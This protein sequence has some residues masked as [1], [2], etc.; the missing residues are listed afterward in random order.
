[1]HRNIRLFY[2]HNLLTDFQFHAPFIVI[3]F[4][5]I[6]GSYTQAM[7]ILSIATITAVLMDIPSGVLSD[8]IGRKFTITMG[9]LFSVLGIS[10]YAAASSVELLYL[11][12]ALCGLSHCMFS[13]NNDALLFE[14]LKEQGKENLF[15][16]Y[17]GRTSSMFQ[18]ALSLSALTAVFLVTDNLRLVFILS[19]VPQVLALI[20]SLMFKSPKIHTTTQR[21]S[22]QHIAESISKIWHNPKLLL[23][24][25]GQSISHG[26][27]EANFEFKTVFVNSLWPIWAVGLYRSLNHVL[28][29]VGFWMAGYLIDK[30]KESRILI[31]REAYELVSQGLAV[32]MANVISPILLFSSSILFG[33]GIVAC[34]HLMQ[35]EFTDEQRAT[36]GSVTSFIGSLVYTIMAII[37]GVIADHWGLTAALSFVIIFGAASLPVYIVLFKKR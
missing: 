19:L 12:A 8:K 4:A 32:L 29:F 10:C 15:H 20:V 36:M 21:T 6:A 3:Y 34:G 26:A 14:T 5:A 2:L 35:K 24:V 28:G 16:H 9:S 27:N 30:F 23:L 13:G 18:I 31:F 11:G 33:P 25:M 1:M 7:T 37:V 17:L 22:W